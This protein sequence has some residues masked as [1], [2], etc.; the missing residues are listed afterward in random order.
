M[1]AGTQRRKVMIQ[2][3]EQPVSLLNYL[4]NWLNLFYL[5]LDTFSNTDRSV[6]LHCL[7]AE[8]QLCKMDTTHGFWDSNT[9]KTKF[10]VLIQFQL[11]HIC[12]CCLDIKCT[13]IN[14]RWWK[15]GPSV[16]FR[17]DLIKRVLTLLMLNPLM[18]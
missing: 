5:L 8:F 1:W 16:M 11:L 15:L 13:F 10:L 17:D 14:S 4:C 12:Y 18:N 7:Q 2:L 3:L 6:V 9:L